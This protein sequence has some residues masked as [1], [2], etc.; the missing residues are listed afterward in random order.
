MSGDEDETRDFLAGVRH[1][2]V[3]ERPEVNRVE[4]LHLLHGSPAQAIIDQAALQPTLVAMA[5][6]GRGGLGRMVMGSVADRVVRHSSAPV[7]LNR[8]DP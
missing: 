5:S 2:L 3:E 1:Q 8:P 6:H 7:L 4:T